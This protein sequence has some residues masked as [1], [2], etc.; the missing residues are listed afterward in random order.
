MGIWCI[1]LA[2]YPD[3]GFSPLPTLFAFW[4]RVAIFGT[5]DWNVRLLS[6]QVQNICRA[7]A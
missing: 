4:W 2:E 3:I 7:T 1:I 6:L 5:F